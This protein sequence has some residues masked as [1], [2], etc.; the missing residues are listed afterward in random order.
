MYMYVYIYV[1]ICIWIVCIMYRGERY[2]YISGHDCIYVYICIY[3]Y[4]C[5]YICI[6]KYIYILYIYTSISNM[7]YNKSTR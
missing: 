6:Y 4:M 3:I 1:Y 7:S 5:V 2:M